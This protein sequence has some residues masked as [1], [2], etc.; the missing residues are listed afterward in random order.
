MKVNDP[1]AKL[2]MTIALYIAT[3]YEE[4]GDGKKFKKTYEA[5]K[6]F[7]KFEKAW[8]QYYRREDVIE[9]LRK[10]NRAMTVLNDIN[11]YADICKKVELGELKPT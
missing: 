10:K 4:N 9:D 3:Y 5:F 6:G 2:N 7:N 11:V 8:D 1:N